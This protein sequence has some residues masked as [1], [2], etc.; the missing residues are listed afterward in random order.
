MADASRDVKK[1]VPA[2][3]AS[4][5]VVAAQ[6]ASTG[7][8]RFTSIGR[9]LLGA[10]NSMS[11]TPSERD[12]IESAMYKAMFHV[13]NG[14]EEMTLAGHMLCSQAPFGEPSKTV[15]DGGALMIGHPKKPAKTP[16]T[17]LDVGQL[18]VW[19]QNLLRTRH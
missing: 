11:L 2:A 12:A 4:S 18:T 17:T 15:V 1:P 14:A 9:A 5:A 3:S 6:A 7:V 10:M 13:A 19:G 16:P 8:M